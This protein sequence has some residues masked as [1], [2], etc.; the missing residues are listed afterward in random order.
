MDVLDRLVS[1]PPGGLAG[2]PRSLS[3]AR[4][5]AGSRWSVACVHPPGRPQPGGLP[6]ELS[7]GSLHCGA[8]LRHSDPV[9]RLRHGRRP[10]ADGGPGPR[11]AGLGRLRHPRRSAACRQRLAG[12]PASS[13]RPL[14]HR[15]LVRPGLGHRRRRGGDDLA[16]SL[17][18]GAL[19]ADGPGARPSVAAAADD[20]PGRRSSAAGLRLGPDGHGAE[21]DRRGGG[22]VAGPVLRAHGPDP[23]RHRRHQGRDPGL[24]PPGQDPGLWRADADRQGPGH[25]ALVDV[26]DRRAAVDGRHRG[27]RPH[28]RPD[29]RCGLQ[30]LDEVDRDGDRVQAA[31]L[32]MRGA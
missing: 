28:P 2:S 25:A 12:H 6:N 5:A 26:R 8:G 22:S 13:A 21:P 19:P 27:R 9:R 3:R 32:F 10:D 31:Q 15:R 16:G 30:E 1:R 14:G 7:R 17:Q 20:Q 29:E 4:R 24:R 18:A 11:P 23:A